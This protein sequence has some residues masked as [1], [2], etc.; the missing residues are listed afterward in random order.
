MS[1]DLK[2]ILIV[3]ACVV[4]LFALVIVGYGLYVY[5]HVSQTF[6]G[7]EDRS[8]EGAEYGLKVDQSACVD[9]ALRRYDPM[10]SL[11]GVSVHAFVRACLSEA[12]PAGDLCVGLPAT[13]DTRAGA[14]WVQNRCDGREAMDSRACL[15]V[16]RGVKSYCESEAEK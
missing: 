8:K 11:A 12:K 13:D 10:A 3:S 15:T 9:E 16:M 1:H 14:A 5:L 2:I 4:G 7:L 6:A